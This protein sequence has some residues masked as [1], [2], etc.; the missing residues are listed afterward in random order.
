MWVQD[1]AALF[2]KCTR[3]ISAA[4]YEKGLAAAEKLL[5]MVDGDPI[6]HAYVLGCKVAVAL[7]HLDRPEEAAEAF[8]A[9]F[10]EAMDAES[11]VIAG[12]IRNDQ[13]SMV[14][15]DAAVEMIDEAINLCRQ[16]RESPDPDRILGADLAYMQATRTRTTARSRGPDHETRTTMKQAR[17][18]LARYAHG[19]HP[20]Y[21]DAYLV[22]LVWELEMPRQNAWLSLPGRALCLG[23]IAIEVVRQKKLRDGLTL[24]ISRVR[25]SRVRPSN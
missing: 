17:S 12:Y 21:L 20:Y 4:D 13:A 7:R 22:V 25:R 5:E 2:E 1:E 19:S 23:R 24:L 18:S 14:T 9:A 16:E 8:E 10:R 15:G 3:A 11:P 6:K